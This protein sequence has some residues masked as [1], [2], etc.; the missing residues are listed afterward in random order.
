[1]MKK[2]QLAQR[3]TWN[4]YSL[5]LI[6]LFTFLTAFRWPLLPTFIDIYYHLSV[7]QGFSEAGGFVAEAFWESAPV[8]RAHVY[9]PLLHFF[10]LLLYKTG[11]SLISVAKVFELITFPLLLGVMWKFMREFFSERIAF[12]AVLL[13][14]SAY[15]LYLATVNFI[16]VSLAV[17]FG[18]LAFIYLEKSK[19]VAAAI[20]LGLC[21]YAH[22]MMPWIF[23]I[24]LIIYGL[25]HRSSLKRC[26]FV[27]AASIIIA[28]PLL[29]HQFNARWFL[30]TVRD[31]ERF[32]IEINLLCYIGA[33]P[34]I[35]IALRRKGRYL[36]I[37]ALLIAHGLLLPFGYYYRTFSGQGIIPLI[38]LSA[39]TVE[40]VFVKLSQRLKNT[41]SSFDMRKSETIVSLSLLV[42]LLFVSPTIVIQKNHTSF[43]LLNSTYTNLIP[44]LKTVQ[45]SNEMTMFFT[46]YFN[47][48]KTIIQENS[49]PEDIIFCDKSYAGGLLS[50]ISKRATS[51]AMMQ[52]VRSF[53]EYD[54]IEAATIII[55]MKNPEGSF[56]LDLAK[57]IK[58]YR[59][60]KIDETEFAH[61][62]K[63]HFAK[64]KKIVKKAAVP[65]VFVFGAL[66]FLI[67]ACV[68]D[69]S[70]KS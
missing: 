12:F 10:M 66:C 43:A 1:M 53:S 63:N 35:F 39:L 38:F 3:S 62:Y 29:I 13:G 40:L 50:V 46:K 61:I 70:K 32:T 25:M 18:L 28:L 55:W 42:S 54:P 20:F 44:G 52:E 8:G 47:E 21:F 5:F 22:G 41:F 36:F 30:T 68:L 26:V 15:S 2:I 27:A 64:A 14:L 67:G 56:D 48:I 58:R 31:V 45:R 19:L 65:S 37:L 4:L 16:P 7:V 59:L 33:L 34:G 69:I 51:T 6:A 49:K 23:V 24:S 60:V 11:V 57:V 9:P 17:I